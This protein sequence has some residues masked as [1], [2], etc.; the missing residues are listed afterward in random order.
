MTERYKK[1]LSCCCDSRSYC[2]QQ[3]DRIEN[4]TFQCDRSVLTCELQLYTVQRMH[5]LSGVHYAH[6][7]HMQIT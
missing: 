6:A 5:A 4:I 3:Y 2:I 7:T 1:K